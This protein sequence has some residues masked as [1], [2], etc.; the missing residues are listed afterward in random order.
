[1]K[2]FTL[3]EIKET[4]YSHGWTFGKYTEQIMIDAKLKEILDNDKEAILAY[5][6]SYNDGFKAGVADSPRSQLNYTDAV[7]FVD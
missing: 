6:S 2:N 5:Q 4:G 7:G 1:M 3:D